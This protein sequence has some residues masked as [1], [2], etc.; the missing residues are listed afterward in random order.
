MWQY[1]NSLNALLADLTKY[2]EASPETVKQLLKKAPGKAY[3]SQVIGAWYSWK[4]AQE[5]HICS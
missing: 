3:V 5:T 4:I 1:L 2:A